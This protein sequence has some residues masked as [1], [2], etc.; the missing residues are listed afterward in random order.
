MLSDSP[1]KIVQKI[2]KAKTDPLPLPVDTKEA[3]KRPEAFN[4]LSIYAV[5]NSISTKNVIQQ[6]AGK[7]FSLFKKD[8]TDLIVAKIHPIGKEI[9]KLMKDQ[10]YLDSIM[11]DG[12]NKAVIEADSVLTKVYDI[13]GLKKS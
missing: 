6:Y 1:D 2:K 11:T 13:I 4:L 12:K 5:L 8:L 9:N 7:E 3:Y 10:L